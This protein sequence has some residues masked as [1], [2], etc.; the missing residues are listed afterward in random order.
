VVAHFFA[1]GFAYEK[2]TAFVVTE[3]GA[4]AFDG[5]AG[6]VT[7]LGV[8]GAVTV[9]GLGTN[10]AG[11]GGSLGFLIGATTANPPNLLPAVVTT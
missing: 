8:G 2:G 3:A 7:V 4:G 6:A 1:G 10:V 11:F 5:D 9:L